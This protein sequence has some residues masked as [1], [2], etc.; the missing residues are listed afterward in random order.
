M[1]DPAPI[2]ICSHRRSG[3]HFLM[4]SIYENF[5]VGN[6]CGA[7]KVAG[8]QW[9]KDGKEIASIPWCNLFGAHGSLSEAYRKRIPYQN[10][11]YIVRHPYDCLYSLWRFWDHRDERKRETELIDFMS[12]DRICRWRDHVT[13]YIGVPTARYEDLCSNFT[14]VM[15]R[16][17]EQFDLKRKHAEIKRPKGLVGWSPQEGHTGYWQDAD[18]AILH[19]LNRILF[20]SYP[21]LEH[22]YGFERIK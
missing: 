13:S 18:P 11:L 4:A 16:I 7:I 21:L 3:T 8:Q 22:R 12:A 14:G 1:S 19:K 9:Y 2:K 17:E 15:E 6:Q 5:E 10:I 20:G